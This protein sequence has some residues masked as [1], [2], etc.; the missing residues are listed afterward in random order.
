VQRLEF[1]YMLQAVVLTC[2]RVHRGAVASRA[3]LEN[4][5]IQPSVVHK[6]HA[7]AHIVEL[8]SEAEVV[9]LG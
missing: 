2:L 6:I 7:P 3:A 9:L 4:M 8:G 5:L 1:G